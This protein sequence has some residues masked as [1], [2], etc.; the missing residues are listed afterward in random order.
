MT[1]QMD[2]FRH[3]ISDLGLQ[4]L[5]FQGNNYTW[6]NRRELDRALANLMWWLWF[7]EAGVLHLLR[8][9]SDHAPI[10]LDC[11]AL[12]KDGGRKPRNREKVFRFEKMWMDHEACGEI[13]VKA[14]DRGNTAL[15]FSDRTLRC[16]TQLKY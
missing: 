16:E 5:G 3:T 13:V 14:W 7:P 11:E 10:L 8:F 4:D 9:K 6:S 2:K 12:S 1:K 15:K